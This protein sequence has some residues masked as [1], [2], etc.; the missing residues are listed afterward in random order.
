MLLIPAL[1]GRSRHISVN[2]GLVYRSSSRTARTSQ[3]NFVSR[4]EKKRQTQGFRGAC[5]SAVS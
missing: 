2:S 4:E 3:R 5:A 1:Q